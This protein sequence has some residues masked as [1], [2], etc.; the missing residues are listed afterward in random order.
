MFTDILIIADI[1][2]TTGCWDTAGSAF[3]TRQWAAAC[4][5]MS[6]DVTALAAALLDAGARRVRI[7]DF[8]RTG[9]NILPELVDR[10]AELISGYR[11]GPVPGIGSVGGAQAVF[12][13][14]LHAA[15]GTPGFLAHTLTSRLSSLTVNGHPMAEIALFAAALAPY[16]VVPVFFSGCPEACRQAAAEVPGIATHPIDKSGGPGSLDTGVWR[17]QLGQKGAAALL[18]SHLEPYRRSG[19]FSVEITFRDGARAAA[20]A[21]RRWQLTR[22]GARVTFSAGDM[23]ALYMTLIRICY[24]TPAVE[25]LLPIGLPLFNLRGRL[26][27]AWARSAI[28]QRR[29]LAI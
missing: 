28:A 2:G 21:A 16:H 18:L 12:F 5:E 22:R 3:L 15:S 1:E 10:R 9:F 11:R 23:A 26:G 7:K 17:R 29:D 25:R 6:L 27:R 8:H 19:P 14:G 4:R 24:L 20:A 13:I